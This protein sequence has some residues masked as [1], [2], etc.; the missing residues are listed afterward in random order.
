[1]MTPRRTNIYPLHHHRTPTHS[2]SPSAESAYTTTTTTRVACC[3]AD[4]HHCLSDISV[5]ASRIP[6]PVVR[7]V[8]FLFF[9]CCVVVNVRVMNS[10]FLDVLRRDRRRVHCAVRGCVRPCKQAASS[11]REVSSSGSSVCGIVYTD[12]GPIVVAGHSFPAFMI[13][14]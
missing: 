10:T 1:M 12:P 5:V 2:P 6:A 9:C 7:V 3:R 8:L 13:R 14:A 11:S 4:L